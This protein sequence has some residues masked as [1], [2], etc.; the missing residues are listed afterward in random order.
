MFLFGSAAFAP[1][2]VAATAPI[3]ADVLSAN[4]RLV[5]D[6]SILISYDFLFPLAVN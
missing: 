3:A 1:M 5:N 4:S 6:F 2:L